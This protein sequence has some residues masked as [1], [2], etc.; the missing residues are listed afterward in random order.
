MAENPNNF[1]PVFLL[2]GLSSVLSAMDKRDRAVLSTIYEQLFRSLDD[3]HH[4]LRQ[5]DQ[6][7]SFLDVEPYLQRDWLL[8]DL[9]KAR[10]IGTPH[11]HF[12]VE[13]TAVGGETSLAV[14]RPVDPGPATLLFYNG[15][16]V[17][18]GQG[19]TFDVTDPVAPLIVFTN[20]LMAGDVVRLYAVDVDSVV[21]YTA[22]GLQVEFVFP[23]QIDTGLV[24]IYHNNIEL[25]S[26][27]SI[28]TRE[29]L[30]TGGLSSGDVVQFR[31]GSL[32]HNVTAAAG[33][34]RVECPFDLTEAAVIRLGGI[35]I[36]DGWVLRGDRIIFKSA[37]RAGVRIRIRA[38]KVSPHDHYTHTEVAVTGQT[39][40]QTPTPL[41]LA[42]GLSYDADRPILVMVNGVLLDTGLYTFTGPDEIS[43]SVPLLAGDRVIVHYHGGDPYPH[44][45][46]DYT[47]VLVNELPAGTG[48]RVGFLDADRPAMVF[49]N[50]VLLFEGSGAGAYQVFGGNTIRFGQTLPANT[51]ILVRAQKY[52]WS[53]RLD[54]PEWDPAIVWV[55][56]IQNGIDLPTRVLA[57]NR[58]YLI[59]DGKL[60]LSEVFADGWLKDVRID[61]QTPYNNFGYLIDFRPTGIPAD[62][63][64]DLL[65]A[66]WAAYVGG[67]RHHV[68]ENF[69]RIMLGSPIARVPGVVIAVGSNTVDIRGDDNVVRRFTLTMP[70]AVTVNQRV[71]RFTALGAGLRILDDVSEP[72]WYRRFPQF[73][74]ALER[75]SPSGFA[76]AALLE[77]GIRST[78]RVSAIAD[79]DV[80]THSIVVT[81]TAFDRTLIEDL[82][83]QECRATIFQ[84]TDRFDT[85][86]VPKARNINNVT[87][88][89]D[90]G[91]GFRVSFDPA[92][93]F[94]TPPA[95]A[96]TTT[97]EFEFERQ[98]RLDRDMVLDA[99]IAEHL[100]PIAEH[101]YRVMRAHL[102][103]VELPTGYTVSQDR[104]SLLVELL[105]RVRAAETN[106]V[107]L[108]ELPA[109]AEDVDVDIEEDS[110]SDTSG[111]F[112]QIPAYLVM[113]VSAYGIGYYG[114]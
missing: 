70:P 9:T 63:Y 20:A 27:I 75:F 49:V 43:L 34:V 108:G 89:E 36:R 28:R 96:T 113:G 14:G 13:F 25:V 103:A 71:D 26:G 53:W 73:L 51:R 85:R 12:D 81:G 65:K 67:P 104:L 66:V 72:D 105:E 48:V 110:P 56:S 55:S 74:Y 83:Q 60:Y 54:T 15:I 79:Y 88:I 64:T 93:P 4:E 11:G 84:G 40:I 78:Y 29:V 42:S 10:F 31:R 39:T 23:Q 61:L 112:A 86:L 107:V 18:Q 111:N 87:A 92:Y 97:V 59:H 37:P 44:A 1:D 101:L 57:P 114:P 100:E 109:L 2:R 95:P 16:Q 76:A 50:G 99:Y 94:L 3:L 24:R 30:F 98:R 102:F 7:K 35:D 90:L 38:P 21:D 58:D 80:S 62:T 32:V 82:N 69:G 46:P 8:R 22:D 68:M 52:Q 91:W 6:S 77:K 19:W 106:Y 5:V 47:D 41:G 45:H 33:Q 17:P